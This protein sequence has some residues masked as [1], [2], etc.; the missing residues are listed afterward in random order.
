MRGYVAQISKDFSLRSLFTLTLPLLDV[1]KGH[2]KWLAARN[3]E[4][5]DSS[6]EVYDGVLA[7]WGELGNERDHAFLSL[8]PLKISGLLELG[9]VILTNGRRLRMFNFRK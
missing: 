6:A 2:P 3:G 9:R 8:K 7:I 4:C 1:T 5:L